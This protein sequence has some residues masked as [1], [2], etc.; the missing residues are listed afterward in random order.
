MKNFGEKVS[1]LEEKYE[2]ILKT[3]EYVIFPIIIATS[4][5]IASIAELAVHIYYCKEC[6][7]FCQRCLLLHIR[8]LCKFPYTKYIDYITRFNISQRYLIRFNLGSKSCSSTTVLERKKNGTSRKI[9]VTTKI[10][11]IDLYATS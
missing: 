8:N 9:K 7:N 11:N 5:L 2:Y 4:Y 3:Y 10:R 1:K 6:I